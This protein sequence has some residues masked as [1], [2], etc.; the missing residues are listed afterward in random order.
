MSELN[1]KNLNEEI[2]KNSLTASATGIEF[3]ERYSDQITKVGASK[4]WRYCMY[5]H[6][7]RY[8]LELGMSV[9]VI[10][11]NWNAGDWI[12]FMQSIENR[13]N[14]YKDYASNAR[15][16]DIVTLIKYLRVDPFNKL[17]QLNIDKQVVMPMMKFTSVF[18]CLVFSDS[19]DLEDC[20][21]SYLKS[22][23]QLSVVRKRLLSEGFEPV[24]DSEEEFRGR[25]IEYLKQIT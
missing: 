25:M 6:D 10:W 24:P 13:P 9:S 18:L 23:K 3:F 11:D 8:A 14:R 1:E 22:Q 5:S 4:F 15:F 17:L 21:G 20:D 19:F 12:R 16:A 2:I 7:L